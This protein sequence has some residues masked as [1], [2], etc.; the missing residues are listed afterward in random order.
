MTTHNRVALTLRCL[1]A[2]RDSSEAGGFDVR[3]VIVDAGSSDGTSQAAT[4]F[5]DAVT[6]IPVSRDVYWAEGMALAEKH[7][8]SELYADDEDVI[9]WL[10]DDV[11][12]DSDAL[13]RAQSEMSRREPTESI[14]VGSMRDES[15]SI[16]YGGIMRSR[17]NPL[18]IRPIEPSTSP[19]LVDTL[20]GNFVLVP[21]PL[22]RRIGGIDGS[23]RHHM[24]DIDY[25]VRARKMGVDVTLMPGTFGVCE[26]GPPVK[27]SLRQYWAFYFS[28][29]GG[30]HWPT[31]V[32]FLMKH[33]SFLAIP[34]LVLMDAIHLVRYILSPLQQMQ[35]SSER[36]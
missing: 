24:A 22:A 26:W 6:V 11:V 25:G 27:R 34:A 2:L 32:T 13:R 7:V 36:R 21:T 19:I 1:K 12:L 14:Y 33:S 5:W 10:N 20:H 16:T 30:G 9:V 15:G 23:F 29:K 18:A 4:E 17:W 31:R 35:G 28:V 3:V 8:M